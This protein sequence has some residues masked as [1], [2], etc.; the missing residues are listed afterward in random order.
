MFEC[1]EK[2]IS[3]LKE[4]RLLQARALG[5]PSFAITR[6]ST[7]EAIA[8]AMPKN[9]WELSRIKGVGPA[10][11]AKYGKCIIQGCHTHKWRVV[12]NKENVADVIVSYENSISAKK[13]LLRDKLRTW[14]DSHRDSPM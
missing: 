11:V 4:W 8:D 13:L 2:L 6:N 14:R 10:T 9:E 5:V 12:S 1:N 3:E 7:L